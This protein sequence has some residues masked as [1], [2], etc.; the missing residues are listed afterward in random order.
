MWYLPWLVVWPF[1]TSFCS[2]GPR[3][4]RVSCSDAASNI[5]S[6]NQERRNPAW[7]G[8]REVPQLSPHSRPETRRASRVRSRSPCFYGCGGPQP[9]AGKQV[10]RLP[11]RGNGLSHS[12]SDRAFVAPNGWDSRS[13]RELRPAM[14]SRST[15]PR[16]A[17]APCPGCPYSRGRSL[18]LRPPQAIVGPRPQLKERVD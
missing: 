17:R 8:K 11:L 5:R 10:T 1:N 6:R 16:A 2:R 4:L 3:G 7:A 14:W 18:P 12:S 9:L 13:S 15:K